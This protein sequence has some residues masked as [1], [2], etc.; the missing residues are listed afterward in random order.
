MVVVPM[1]HMFPP[2]RMTV[3]LA[4]EV[5]VVREGMGSRSARSGLTISCGTTRDFR[6]VGRDHLGIPMI[7]VRVRRRILLSLQLIRHSHIIR[8][9]WR[10]SRVR[11]LLY[12]MHMLSRHWRRRFQ[13]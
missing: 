11:H 2:V 9:R 8:Y 7:I 13:E 12:R 1:F 6:P 10:W 4:A 3:V 5:V